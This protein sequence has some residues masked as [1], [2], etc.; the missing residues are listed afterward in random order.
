MRTSEVYSGG[1]GTIAAARRTAAAFLAHARTAGHQPAVTPEAGY[2]T[3]LVVSELVTNAVKHA[4]GICGL[5]L[6][7]TGAVVEI[8]VWDTSPHEITL[9]APDP[10]RV[11]R[12]G[13]EIVIALCGGLHTART[14]T[15]K[16]IT[17]R[18]PLT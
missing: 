7:L 11:G 4:A 5:D 2:A 16:Q 13:L 14:P 18:V 8:T 12:H 6:R 3:E 1:P 9:S 17:A 15:G 10:A